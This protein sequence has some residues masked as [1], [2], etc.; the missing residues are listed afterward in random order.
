MATKR[1]VE[2]EPRKV[3]TVCRCAACGRRQQAPWECDRCGSPA[4][5]KDGLT[6]SGA[7]RRSCRAADADT[8]RPKLLNCYCSLHTVSPIPRGGPMTDQPTAAPVAVHVH[9][10]NYAAATATAQASA[11]PASRQSMIVA[12]LLW[13]VGWPLALH[14]LYLDKSPG[15]WLALLWIGTWAVGVFAPSDS[16]AILIPSLGLPLIDAFLIP[17][18]VRRHNAAR[19]T[20]LAHVAST[21]LPEGRDVPSGAAVATAPRERRPELRTRLLRA[22]H[23]GDGRL[24]LTQAVME[25]EADFDVV[26]KALRSLLTAGHIDVDNDPD[27]GVVL[28]LFP[29][30][31]GRPTL[32]EPAP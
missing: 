4:L 32:Q 3:A 21:P 5:V 12:Y 17:G 24:T 30:L 14:R 13:T 31:V 11:A 15:R 28:Y 22:A 20:A 18:W 9:N 27:S 6:R 7:Y 23:R 8:L 2:R 26:D 10:T 16:Y 1:R 19:E 25:T 29:E